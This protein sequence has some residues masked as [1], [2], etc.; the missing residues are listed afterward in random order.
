LRI[1]LT[2]GFSFR[3]PALRL[4]TGG[5]KNLQ[6]YDDQDDNDHDPDDPVLHILPPP[7]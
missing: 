3:Y 2:T 1:F 7:L 6:N 5:L 4:A